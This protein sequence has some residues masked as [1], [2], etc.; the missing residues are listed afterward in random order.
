MISIIIPLRV[1][2]MSRGGESTG[3][4]SI[5]ISGGSFKLALFTICSI[6]RWVVVFLREFY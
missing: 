4:R 1:G 2:G 5:K 3:R 6:L